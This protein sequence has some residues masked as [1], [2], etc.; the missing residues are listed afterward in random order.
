MTSILEE[1][2]HLI[3]YFCNERDCQ[4]NSEVLKLDIWARLRIDTTLSRTTPLSEKANFVLFE[5]SLVVHDYNIH[6]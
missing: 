6:E 5:E 1:F 3:S 2:C 4:V